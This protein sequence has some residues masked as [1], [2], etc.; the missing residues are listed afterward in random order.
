MFYSTWWLYQKV[1]L[2]R[3]VRP[4]KLNKYLA[5]VKDGSKPLFIHIN[6]TAGSSIAKSLEIT[7]AHF[8]LSEY[9]NIYKNKFGENLPQNIDIWTSIRNPFDRVASEYHYRIKTNQNKMQVNPIS[10]DEWVKKVFVEKDPSY[11][12][13]EIMFLNQNEWVKGTKNYNINFI[14]FENLQEDFQKLANEY[15]VESLPWKKKSD[16]LNYKET[17]SDISKETIFQ[18]FKEDLNRFNYSF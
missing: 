15:K 1:Y 10:F 5:Q 11:R 13:R 3:L 14:R 6:K 8:T 7:E 18:V 2:D 17:F 16:N 12:D 4:H 9:E